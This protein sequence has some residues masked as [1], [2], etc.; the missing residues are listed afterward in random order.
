MDFELTSEQTMLRSLAR[1]L[2]SQQCPP[3]VVRQQAESEPGY[4]EALWRQLAEIGLQGVA[5]PEQHG[6]QGLGMIELALVLDEMGRAAYPG[7]FFATTVLAASALAASGDEDHQKRY[8][9]RIATGDLKATLALSGTGLSWDAGGVGVRAQRR[10]NDYVL[11]GRASYVPFAHVADLLLVAARTREGADPGAGLTIFALEPGLAGLTLLPNVEI[12]LTNRSA[13]LSFDQVRVSSDTVLGS[14]D[15]GGQIL[16]ATLQRAAVGAAA[17]MLGASRRCLEMS[18]E[19]ARV[20]E[21][22]GQ[23]IG[24]FQAIKHYCADMLVEVENMHSSTYYAAWALDAGAP[25]AALAAAVA[26]SYAGEGSRKVCGQ[27]I[28]VHG[29]IGFTWDYDLHL[30]FKRAKHFEPLYGDAEAQRELALREVLKSR[31]IPV[32][33]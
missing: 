2:L 9:P 21:Q 24:A 1:E 28:Q 18:V 6:G 3:S 15:E 22:F 16:E 12:D 10:G 7:P 5:I 26:K 32:L 29:G 8:L 31:A 11:S 19:Y 17:E 23:K 27:S 30:F 13:N 20:R 25:D 14:V 33:A 4:D